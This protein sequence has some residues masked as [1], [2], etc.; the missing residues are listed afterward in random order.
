MSKFFVKLTGRDAGTPL[1]ISLDHITT[2]ESDPDEPGAN[3]SVVGEE[4]YVTVR[5]TPSEVL[6]KIGAVEPAPSYQQ[7]PQSYPKEA[8]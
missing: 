5:E 6:I 8:S 4:A 3:L 7:N 2:V 1:W